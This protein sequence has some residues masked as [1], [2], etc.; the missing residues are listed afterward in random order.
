MQQI[1]TLRTLILP[2]ALL[3]LFHTAFSGEPPE[4]QQKPLA[5]PVVKM[6]NKLKFI[7]DSVIIK[8]GDTVLWRNTSLLIHTVTADSELAAKKQNVALPKNASP[9]NSG[10]IKPGETFNRTFT[11]PGK[12]RYF[13]MP[14]E[15]TGMV[16]VIVVKA[17]K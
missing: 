5:A 15:A 8:S 2:V 13:C 4:N 12:Y 10:K 11:V 16:G 1:I 14:H 6:T 3:I 7:P 9:F 17:E